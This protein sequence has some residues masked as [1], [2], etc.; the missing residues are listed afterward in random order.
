MST[1]EAQPAKP[2][3]PQKFNITWISDDEHL[4]DSP[5]Y[6]F[7]ADQWEVQKF[8]SEYIRLMGKSKNGP[9]HGKNWRNISG[10]IKGYTPEEWIKEYEK[11]HKEALTGG[12]VDPNKV[13]DQEGDLKK[14][15]MVD[16]AETG[17]LRD[18]IPKGMTPLLRLK[19]QWEREYAVY[20]TLKEIQKGN[21]AKLIWVEQHRG[22]KVL[23]KTALG[24][25]SAD[26]YGGVTWP[27]HSGNEYVVFLST[28]NWSKKA[29]NGDNESPTGSAIPENRRKKP[30]EKPRTDKDTHVQLGLNNGWQHMNGKR[31]TPEK[32]QE[33]PDKTEAGAGGNGGGARRRRRKSR[34]RKSKK[35]KKSKKRRKSRKRKSRRKSKKSR[36][37]KR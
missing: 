32:G 18:A 27:M 37:R 16:G 31:P 11:K 14:L 28:Y 2:W 6:V 1:G 4:R 5:A 20:K 30:Y 33:C 8:I 29:G 17:E 35:S 15:I 23:Q 24:F 12:V 10:I 25:G 34:R 26:R 9:P 22:D 3:V 13:S 19:R 36:R 21:K 7:A